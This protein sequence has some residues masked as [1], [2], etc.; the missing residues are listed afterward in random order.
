[1]VNNP[2]TRD[3]LDS[4]GRFLFGRHRG[5]TVPQVLQDDTGAD[6]IRWALDNADDM[7][8]DD[9]Q[10]LESYLKMRGRL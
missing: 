8:E 2:V 7:S 4:S 5:R 6:Y 9:R 3:W 10:I 1:V